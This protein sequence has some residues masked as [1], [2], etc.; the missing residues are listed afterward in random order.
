ML[1]TALAIV[2]LVL[3]ATA[4]SAGAAT[5]PG[6]VSAGAGCSV[7]CIVKALVHPTA[8]SAT[9]DVSTS[10]PASVTVEAAKLGGAPSQIAAPG[11][12]THVS[13]PAFSLQRTILLTGLEP[14]TTYRI[15]VTAKDIQGH[16]STRIG[17]FTTRKV[18]VAVDTDVD[19][20]DS[21]LGCSVACIQKAILTQSRSKQ[22]TATVDFRSAVAARLRLVVS[23]AGKTV[24]DLSSGPA[25]TSWTPTVEGLLSGTRYAVQARATDAQGRTDVR[26]GSFRTVDAIARVTLTKIQ[27]I[28]DADKGGNAGELRFDYRVNGK[29]VASSG[30]RKLDSGSTIGV[31]VSGTSRPGVVVVVPTGEGAILDVRV[32]GHE[33]DRA[34]KKNCLVEEAEGTPDPY[35]DGGSNGKKEQHAWAVGVFGFEQLLLSGTLPPWYG[36]GVTPPAGH[37]GYFLVQTTEFRVK[38]LVLGYVDIEHQFSD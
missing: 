18:E 4:G 21:G 26:T 9:V 30:V 33:C 24:A 6:T 20:F 16:K 8:S 12:G 38:F 28:D 7:Q 35:P 22:S 11:G 29:Q 13:Q 14:E 37:D 32:R 23:I 27:V 5:G 1:R 31:P 34:M 25:T 3:A 19:S 2:V 17:T 15:V 10:V 36:T